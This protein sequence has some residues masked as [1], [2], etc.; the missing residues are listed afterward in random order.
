MRKKR[1]YRRRQKPPQ[2]THHPHAAAAAAMATAASFGDV[3]ILHHDL[4]SSEEDFMSPVSVCGCV[5][6]CVC[7]CVCVDVCTGVCV[8]GCVRRCVCVCVSMLV[9]VNVPD[10]GRQNIPQVC[11]YKSNESLFW[12]GCLFT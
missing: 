1:P 12:F 9:G 7:V 4:D 11:I 8:C 10:E 6:R 3:D 5:R 2:P